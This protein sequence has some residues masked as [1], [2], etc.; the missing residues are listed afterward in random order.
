MAPKSMFGSSADMRAG[1][2]AAK[3][4]PRN[5]GNFLNRE[6]A[7]NAGNTNP[8]RPAPLTRI[9]TKISRYSDPS[10]EVSTPQANEGDPVPYLIGRRMLPG[11]NT[12][13]TSTPITVQETKLQTEYATYEPYPTGPGPGIVGKG[14]G[15][16]Y[17]VVSYQTLALL[18]PDFE[19]PAPEVLETTLTTIVDFALALCLGPDVVLLNV[20]DEAGNVVMNEVTPGQ[21]SR[22]LPPSVGKGFRFYSGAWDQPRDPTIAKL[23][24]NTSAYRG[25]SYIVYQEAVLENG[26]PIASANFELLRPVNFL[27][28]EAEQAFSPELDMNI[29]NAIIDL[30][31]NAW[32]SIGLSADYIDVPTFHAAGIVLAAEGNWCSV[33]VS[34]RTSVRQVISGLTAQANGCMRWNPKVGK[35][36]FV[37]FREAEDVLLLPLFD[38]TNAAEISG[39]AKQ[40]WYGM[41][42]GINFAFIDRAQRYRDATVRTGINRESENADTI[43]SEKFDT[44]LTTGTMSAVIKETFKRLITPVLTGDIQAGRDAEL[45]FPGDP[46]RVTKENVRGLVNFPMRITSMKEGGELFDTYTMTV[47]Q[48]VFPYRKAEFDVPANTAPNTS[49]TPVLP[50]VEQIERFNAPLYFLSRVGG[51]IEGTT[52][53]GDYP[54][55]YLMV[56]TGQL[57]S[58]DEWVAETGG[59]YSL[60]NVVSTGN[61]TPRGSLSAALSANSGYASGG[62][63]IE[64]EDIDFPAYVL[65][66]ESNRSSGQGL[67][68]IGNELLF[69]DFMYSTGENSVGLYGVTRGMID[70]VAMAHSAGAQVDFLI[71]YS[72]VVKISTPDTPIDLIVYGQAGFNRSDDGTGVNFTWTPR[73]K[74]PACPINGQVQ[75]TNT[76][77]FPRPS[78]TE[79]ARGAQCWVTW[80]PRSRQAVALAFPGEVAQTVGEP[81]TYTVSLDGAVLASGVTGSA[82]QVLIPTGGTIGAREIKIRAVSANG[83]SLYEETAKF[84]V[85]A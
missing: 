9:D 18:D 84:I 33:L 67:I 53:N 52:L 80:K 81:T 4:D 65:R 56:R 47:T 32:G 76:N 5:V 73:A 37:L 78:D 62:V 40:T 2:D 61:P 26:A 48:D 66:T 11:S 14:F 23:N 27:E 22:G 45:L 63:S 7:I 20:Y 17:K 82:V 55:T 38:K 64:I 8:N 16:S 54:V 83:N 36:Q 50:T 44:I 72:S 3:S 71:D 69:Y 35:L 29:A 58:A 34:G 6:S 49:P 31:M 30:L 39:L 77:T 70:T 51:R 43:L 75:L 46:I 59:G 10:V 13:W 28:Y 15:Y 57:Y 60:K 1:R 25:I 68:K 19:A 42:Q 85:T 24:P 21:T 41:P 12:I 74:L 79:V